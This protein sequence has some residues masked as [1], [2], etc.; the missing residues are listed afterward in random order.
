MWSEFSSKISILSFSIFSCGMGFSILLVFIRVGMGRAN[1]VFG[2]MC[3]VT[4]E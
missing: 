1:N 4:G 2:G 3:R